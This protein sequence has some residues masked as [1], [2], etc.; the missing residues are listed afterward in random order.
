MLYG[1]VIGDIVGSRFERGYNPKKKN[2]ELF[3][4]SNRYTDDTVMT[5]AIYEATKEIVNSKCDDYTASCLYVDY[6]RKW[7]R[8][9]PNAGYGSSFVGWLFSKDP[10]PYNSWGNGSAMR[11]SAIG[12]LFNT[13]SETEKYARLSAEVTHNHPEGI[14][15]AVAVAGAIYLARTTHNKKKI[16]RYISNMGYTLKYSLFVRPKYKFDVSCQGT[17]PVAVEAF[18]ES[19]SF[20]DALRIAVSMGGD[21]DTIAAIA[22]S[23][24]EAYYGVPESFKNECHKYLDDELFTIIT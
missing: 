12:Y 24:A 2:F 4:Y 19:K 16:R 3:H 10:K 23:I 14:K 13:L 5:I 6:L 1:A 8:L 18:L 7:G 11:V 9:Y 20:E 22:G 21:S 17:I 15:G